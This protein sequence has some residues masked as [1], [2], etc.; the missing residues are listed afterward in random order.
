MRRASGKLVHEQMAGRSY[1]PR[2]VLQYLACQPDARAAL[3]AILDQPA[4]DLTLPGDL[5]V[6]IAKLASNC[7]PG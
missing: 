2:A 7:P 3:A 6:E 1:R 5:E 4:A